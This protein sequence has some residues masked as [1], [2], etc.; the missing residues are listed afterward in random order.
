MK[1]NIV[2][3]KSLKMFL[4]SERLVGGNPQKR[5]IFSRLL[6][7]AW[8]QV[9][10][11]SFELRASIKLRAPFALRA[12]CVN[13]GNFIG[14]FSKSTRPRPQWPIWPILDK[15]PNFWAW[16]SETSAPHPRL[17]FWVFSLRINENQQN[18]L[19]GW[20]L[21]DTWNFVQYGKIQGKLVV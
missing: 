13:I 15:N 21:E 7:H 9:L 10:S 18:A 12:P 19:W 14:F 5:S 11:L 6:H 1:Q 4:C 17:R 8:S 16:F 20:T 2:N 3:Q